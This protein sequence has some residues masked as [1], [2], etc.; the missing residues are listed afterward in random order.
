MHQ[1]F[2][3]YVIKPL[4]NDFTNVKSRHHVDHR[5]CVRGHRGIENALHWCLDVTFREVEIWVRDR[6][7][8]DSLAWSKR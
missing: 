1:P 4:N 8:A 3:N 7:L 5:K 2:I 6:I